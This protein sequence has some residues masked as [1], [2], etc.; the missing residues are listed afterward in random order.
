MKMIPAP[1]G[2]GIIF[3]RTDVT[4]E[5]RASWERVV[6]LPRC[7][8]LADNTGHWSEPSSI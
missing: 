6:E 3:R 7:T 8:A 2:T 4:A 1:T 5:I